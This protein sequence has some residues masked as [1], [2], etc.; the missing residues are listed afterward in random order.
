MS[1]WQRF[2]ARLVTPIDRPPVHV[3]H[4][5]PPADVVPRLSDVEA[6]IAKVDAQ[7]RE[8]IAVPASERT[9]ADWHRL[10][11]LLELRNAIRPGRDS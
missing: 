4:T 5:V 2:Y 6:R 7:I 3:E 1:P 9:E 8:A 10:D 11:R